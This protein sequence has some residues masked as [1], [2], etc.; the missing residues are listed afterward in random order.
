ML[1]L[2]LLCKNDTLQISFSI[3]QM[4]TNIKPLLG[5]YRYPLYVSCGHCPSCLQAKSIRNANKIKNNVPYDGHPLLLFVTLTYD[6]R[7]VPYISGDDLVNGEVYKSS[8]FAKDDNKDAGQLF[9]RIPVYRNCKTDYLDRGRKRVIRKKHI[10]DHVNVPLDQITDVVPSLYRSSILRGQSFLTP[11]FN[12]KRLQSKRHDIKL[13]YYGV[14]RYDDFVLFMKRLRINLQRQYGFSLPISYF[15]CTELGPD[16]HRPHLHFLACVPRRPL[17]Y[18]QSAIA[19]AWPFARYKQ[20]REQVQIAIDAASY[21]ASY[22]SSVTTLPTLFQKTFKP[23]HHH[24]KGF[25]FG[26]KE[27]SFESVFSAFCSGNLRYNSKRTIDHAVIDVPVLL[28]QYVINRYAP[29]VKGYSCLTSDEII[30]LYSGLQ[31]ARKFYSVC[32]FTETDVRRT[33]VMLRNRRKFAAA[34]GLSPIDYGIFVSRI[35]TIYNSNLRKL[36]LENIA[37][38]INTLNFNNPNFITRFLSISNRCLR[39]I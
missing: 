35:W 39:V 8:R 7:H 33:E 30:A 31:P 20:T 6:N 29:K 26:R 36:N 18:W 5:R 11:I 38:N 15:C 13:P 17:E 25:G 12:F 1:F 34:H 14:P 22:V 3:S 19:K 21:I 2:D 4:C 28:P 9:K 24:S 16:T 10:I 32:H 23:E 37:N 27:F